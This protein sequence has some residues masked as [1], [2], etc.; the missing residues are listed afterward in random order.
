MAQKILIIEDEESLMKNLKLAIDGD[1]KISTSM[2]GVEG[3]AKA[4]KELPDL[5]LLDIML[6][7]MNGIEILQALKA[8]EKTDSIPVIVMTNLSDQ[9]TVS[10]ILAAGGKEYL[11]KS[12]WSI[13]DIVKK[14]EETLK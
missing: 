8:D 4:K 3:L 9:G 10:Q 6:P 2:S 7:D 13:D 1:Y 11:V 5:I 12:D 14:V